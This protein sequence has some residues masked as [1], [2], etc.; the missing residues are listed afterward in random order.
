[1]ANPHTLVPGYGNV[2]NTFIRRIC[3]DFD[4]LGY[5]HSPSGLTAMIVAVHCIQNQIPFTSVYDEPTN[6]SVITRTPK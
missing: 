1:M 2:R 3:A 4:R 5:N 6:C